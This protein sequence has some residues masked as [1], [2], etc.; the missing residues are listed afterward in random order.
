MAI[1][2]ALGFA[3]I[4]VYFASNTALTTLGLS[5]QY[6]ASTSD[7]QR[8]MLLA[9]G[10][11]SVAMN[12]FTAHGAYPGAGG[13][14]SLLFIAAA[15][16]ITSVVM[17]QSHLFSRLIAYVGVLAG[18]LDLAY[19]VAIL[20]APASARELL[21]LAFIPLAGLLLMVWHLLAGWRLYRLSKV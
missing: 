11:A 7:A 9:A 14:L 13:Y 6:A 21:G 20:V 3:G 2:V 19:C 10:Q 16:V 12:R 8:S 17:L 15:G 18:A 5:E 4:I 1:A